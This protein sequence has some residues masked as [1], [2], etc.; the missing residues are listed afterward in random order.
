M[1]EVFSEV[2]EIKC[3]LKA[4]CLVGNS[5][6]NSPTQLQINLLMICIMTIT[7]AIQQHHLERI[8]ATTDLDEGELNLSYMD[9]IH[10]NNCSTTWVT[11]CRYMQCLDIQ[12]SCR[13]IITS[14]FTT[15]IQ[16]SIFIQSP[17]RQFPVMCRCDKRFSISCIRSLYS[18]GQG[19][20]QYYNGPY[21]CI[22][23]T[24]F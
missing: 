6:L 16:V 2:C 20:D 24:K 12:N 14:Y 13:S 10:I 23:R 15:R 21:Q 3:N 18:T 19:S 17:F 4:C 5:I 8:A 22:E 11:S 9:A 1:H 7:L